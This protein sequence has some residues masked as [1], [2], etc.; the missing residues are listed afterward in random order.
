MFGREE[1]QKARKDKNRGIERNWKSGLFVRREKMKERK[2]RGIK[3]HEGPNF[4]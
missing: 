2:D 4:F 1:K 3:G